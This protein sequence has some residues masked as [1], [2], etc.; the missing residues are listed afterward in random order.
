MYSTIMKILETNK[1][2]KMLLLV[3]LLLFHTY[4]KWCDIDLIDNKLRYS[5]D[6]NIL[7]VEYFNYC[8]TFKLKFDDNNK[9]IS[10]ENINL[11]WV[12]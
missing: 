3:M 2:K 5:F 4:K 12:V 6:G 10:I 7:L 1:D 9:I 11:D 8:E